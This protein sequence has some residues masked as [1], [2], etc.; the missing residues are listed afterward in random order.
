MRIAV[1]GPTHPYKGGI[2]QHTTELAR[3]LSLR[4]HDVRLVTWQNQYPARLY[5]GQLTVDADIAEGAQF[6]SVHRILNWY[7]PS[8]WLRAG[9]RTADADL[10]VVAYSNPFQVPAYRALLASA[11]AGGN[12]PRRVLIAHNVV[13]HDAPV[14]QQRAIDILAA[15][16]DGVVVHSTAD[17]AD[18]TTHLRAVPAVQVPIPP[19]GPALAVTGVSGPDGR[20][21][22]ADSA[23]SA[24]IADIA[25]SAHSAHIGTAVSRAPG[26]A[27]RVLVFGFIRPYKGI[28]ML[29]EAVRAAPDIH[30]TIRGECWDDSLD[31]QIRE[32]AAA[33]ELRGRIDY[34][35]GYLAGHDVE[36][37]MAQHDVV[38]LPYLE[39]TGSQNT[40]LAHAYGLP[41][42]VSDL[43]PLALDVIDQVNGRVLPVGDSAAWA[44][45]LRELDVALIAQWR[46]AIVLPDADQAWDHYVDVV[47]DCGVSRSNESLAAP[48]RHETAAVERRTHVVAD[49][50]SRTRKAE[51]IAAM[52]TAERPLRGARIL[53]NGCGSGYIAHELAKRVG[54]NG[55]VTAVDR[56]DHRLIS[57]GFEFIQTDGGALPFPSGAFDI[58]VSNHV[59]EHVGQPAEQLAYLTEI[60][61]VLAPDGLLY[62]AAPNK[63]RLVEAHVGL[64]FVSW[65]PPRAADRVV[66]LAR[67]GEWYDV[68]PVSRS[69][70]HSLL[71]RAGFTVVDMTAEVAKRQ[72]RALP[73]PV[74]AVAA[75]PGPLLDGALAVVPTFIVLARK[76]AGS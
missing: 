34:E 62:L 57:T 38:A 18:V 35:P 50:A 67:R 16:L 25:D 7:D 43:P 47:L 6:E 55:S 65:L 52:L 26:D 48:S 5:P 4:G 54:P 71:T 11:S 31:A 39:A 21:D 29:L 63:Y 45:A 23:D 73:S 30:V 15:D 58:V 19:H 76:P 74:S 3:R 75:V 1:V 56:M 61:R 53:D 22:A 70:L 60:E 12:P 68:V 72:L 36:S 40:R 42:L 59:L 66:R 44:Q 13:S 46:A 69:Q 20:V 49:E 33:P 51:A 24:H 10:I 64:P 9:R 28:P 32:F 8:S 27:I 37:L 14:W 2:A 17:L 41:A